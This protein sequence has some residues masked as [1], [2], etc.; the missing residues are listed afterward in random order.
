[1]SSGGV[2]T[3]VE[4]GIEGGAVL[5]AAPDDSEPGAGQ[6]ADGMRWRQPRPTA[7]W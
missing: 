1:M 2:A 5:P 3:A 7:A 4:R 6:D